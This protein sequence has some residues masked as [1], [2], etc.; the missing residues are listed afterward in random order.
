MRSY[1]FSFGRQV[2]ALR[3]SAAVGLVTG[4]LLGCG[5]PQLVPQ[6]PA[7]GTLAQVESEGI[8]VE[9][10]AESRDRPAYLP[11]NV[12]PVQLTIRNE[13][14]HGIHVDVDAIELLGAA[15]PVAAS[16]QSI[17][18]LAP[19]NSLGLDPAS[20]LLQPGSATAD[21]RSLGYGYGFYDY[22]RRPPLSYW[23][24]QFEASQTE[25]VAKAFDGGFIDAG[26][27]VTGFLYFKGPYHEGQKLELVIPIHKGQGSGALTTIE[28]PFVAEG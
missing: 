5:T 28:L 26:E 21:S 22:A 1:S 20:P 3:A 17:R 14:D 15:H 24:H 27:T 4:V 2:P 12:T 19:I 25:I 18:P 10:N 9:A 7:N 23:D 6:L 11:R 16:P 8:A 13:S